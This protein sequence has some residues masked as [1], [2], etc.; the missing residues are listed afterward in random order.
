MPK[1]VAGGH[2]QS[3]LVHGAV[4]VVCNSEVV[5]RVVRRQDLEGN[6][7]WPTVVRLGRLHALEG[8]T[9]NALPWT[10]IV[11]IKVGIG[12]RSGSRNAEKMASF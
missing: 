9:T 6:W 4:I 5:M 3:H 11:G 7:R 10:E 8:S 2:R 1:V 12:K